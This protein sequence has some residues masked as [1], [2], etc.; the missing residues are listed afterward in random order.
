[1]LNY[2]IAVGIDISLKKFNAAIVTF[3]HQ[4]ETK[5]IDAAVFENNDSGFSKFNQWVKKLLSDHNFDNIHFAME[6]T[7]VFHENLAY[8][9]FDKGYNVYVIQP[10]MT[11]NF[12]KSL[13]LTAKNDKVD[14]KIIA[15]FIL[16]NN[17]R[18]WSPAHKTYLK[19][20]KLT[21]SREKLIKIKTMISN[22]LTAEKRSHNPDK[23]V[24]KG[25][26]NSINAI[27]KQVNNLEKKAKDI[28]NNDP[29]LKKELVILLQSLA[30]AS[31]LLLLW[32]L[33]LSDSK[34]SLL[35]R[36]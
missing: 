5:V 26:E 1:M 25:F 31:L 29:D 10:T 34:I 13:G 27:D 3:N 7:S 24:I 30:S 36:N 8:F 6:A 22:S 20:R 11:K 16:F 18:K 17:I 9:L 35:S 15:R 21:R 32:S 23:E 4:L 12:F 33:K 28:V 2:K 19:L 14:A